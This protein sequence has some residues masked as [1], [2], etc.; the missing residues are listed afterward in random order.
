M[1]LL[2]KLPSTT[3]MFLFTKTIFLF[4]SMFDEERNNGIVL[5]INVQLDMMSK[6]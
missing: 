2:H 5:K 3:L 6:R 1:G 4:T